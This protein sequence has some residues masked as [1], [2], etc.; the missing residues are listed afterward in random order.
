[1]ASVNQTRPHCVNQMGK[2]HSKPLAAGHGRGLPWARHMCE[3]A[4][5]LLFKSVPAPCMLRLYYYAVIL[6]KCPAW[7][8]WL[9]LNI[10]RFSWLPSAS[11]GNFRRTKKFKRTTMTS[12]SD[13]CYSK[14]PHTSYVTC[15]K[16]QHL[17]LTCKTYETILF[18]CR[19]Y[20]RLHS[21]AIQHVIDNSLRKAAKGIGYSSLRYC[22]N[23]RICVE[24]VTESTRKCQNIRSLDRDLNPGPY[25]YE[26]G[27]LPTKQR[28]VGIRLTEK[29]N[30]ISTTRSVTSLRSVCD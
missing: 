23:P 28:Q 7:N 15:P 12:F 2:T 1:M 6:C 29:K 18:L 9:A 4:L 21:T 13:S 19:I 3:S 27:V 8:F 10:L 5:N 17:T 22:K 11:P 26:A 30:Y 24:G 20:R 25:K 14:H 16:F